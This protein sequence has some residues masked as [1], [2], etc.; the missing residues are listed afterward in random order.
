MEKRH[1]NGSIV[2]ILQRLK[3]QRLITK[4]LNKQVESFKSYE[5]RKEFILLTEDWTIDNELLT[6]TLKI[7]RKNVEEKYSDMVNT[8]YEKQGMHA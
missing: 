4:R 8:V 3:I 2:E 1:I 5:K 6:P 7:K